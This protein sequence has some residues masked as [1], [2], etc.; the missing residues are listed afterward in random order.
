M[1]TPSVIELRNL[2]KSFVSREHGVRPVIDIGHL[3]ICAGEFF[4]IVGPSGCGKS[5]LLNLMTGLLHPDQGEVRVDGKRLSA[6]S[7]QFLQVSQE[8][9]LF[10]W[11]TVWENVHFGLEIGPRRED[12]AERV[13]QILTLVGLR[14]FEDYFPSQ[15]SGG[16]RQRVALARALVV[17]PEILLLDEPFGALDALTRLMLRE[18]LMR[19]WTKTKKT[20]VLVTHDIDEAVACADRIAVMSSQPGRI[21]QIIPVKLPRPRAV[22]QVFLDV[23]EQIYRA[24]VNQKNTF[25][26]KIV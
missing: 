19:I 26:D 22:S 7:P 8:G 12:A 21:A 16:M 17:D 5:T 9:G 3:S 10:P 11:R 14:G 1:S 24:V 25:S 4:A 18:E 20:I 6:P 2:E 15:I 23:R 13:R